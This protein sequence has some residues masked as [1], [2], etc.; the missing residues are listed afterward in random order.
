MKNVSVARL[1]KEC[2]L[3]IIATREDGR[4]YYEIY[5]REELLI[6]LKGSPKVRAFLLGY[7]WSGRPDAAREFMTGIPTLGA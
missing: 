7:L 2:E 3:R 1:K 6:R 4:F 5:K